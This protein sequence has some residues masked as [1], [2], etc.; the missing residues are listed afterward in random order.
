MRSLVF[1][2]LLGLLLW[3]VAT[4]FTS[5]GDSEPLEGTV[6]RVDVEGVFVSPGSMAPVVMLAERD[7]RRTLPIWVGYLE[8]EAIRRNLTGERESRPMTHDL[9]GDAVRSLGGDV[10]RIVVTRLDAGTFFARVHLTARGDTLS[11]DARPSDAIA[12]ALGAGAP[13]FVARRVL[14]EA[15][16]VDPDATGG[17]DPG[18]VG[19]GLYCQP[20]DAELALALGVESGVLVADVSPAHVA[21]DIQRGDVIVSLAGQ[22]AESPERIAELLSGLTEGDA[23]PVEIVRGGERLEILLACP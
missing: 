1:F 20:L 11:L 6:V 15:G 13:I 10:E 9:L 7:G 14:D 19:C 8:A 18:D 21:S 23:L 22:A 16:E 2:T 4:V 12:L 3:G 5:S 17:D